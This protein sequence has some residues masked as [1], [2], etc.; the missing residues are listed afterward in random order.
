MTVVGHSNTSDDDYAAR[1][2]LSSAP[3]IHFA[4][5]SASEG[6]ISSRDLILKQSMKKVL[7]K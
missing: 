6:K 4:I 2:Q 5:D 3:S 1:L 7:K